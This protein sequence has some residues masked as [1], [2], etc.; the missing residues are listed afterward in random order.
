MLITVI[1]AP[2]PV[3]KVMH[4]VNPRLAG[5]DLLFLTKLLKPLTGDDSSSTLTGDESSPRYVLSGPQEQG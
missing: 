5:P 1:S 3:T 2:S 4:S